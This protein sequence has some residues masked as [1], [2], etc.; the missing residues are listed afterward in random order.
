MFF[1]FRF[2]WRDERFHPYPKSVKDPPFLPSSPH[3]DLP[4]TIHP[5][6]SLR[7]ITGGLVPLPMRFPCTF[8]PVPSDGIITEN[9][10]F[11]TTMAPL[12]VG[13]FLVAG[14]SFGCR[15]FFFTF[16]RGQV[17]PPPSR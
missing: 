12:S 13:R 16:E 11:I 3:P 7:P 1:A 17:S 10:F 4:A 8:C 5:I 14:E 15:L 9:R 2:F 6:F